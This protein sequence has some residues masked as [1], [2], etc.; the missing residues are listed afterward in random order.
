MFLPEFVNDHH[1]WRKFLVEADQ[2]REARYQ[3]NNKTL[4]DGFS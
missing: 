1:K 3:R 2:S 4:S